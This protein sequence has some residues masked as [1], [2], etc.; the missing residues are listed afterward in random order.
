M[1]VYAGE[2]PVEWSRRTE[3]MQAF[4]FFWEEEE[5]GKA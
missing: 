4:F 2:L 5:E 3:S 1:S